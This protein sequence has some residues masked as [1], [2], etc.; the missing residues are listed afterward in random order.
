M[1]GYTVSAIVS[2]GE[3][4]LKQT[5]KDQP[6]LVLMD[7]VLQGETTGIDT[8]EKIRLRFDVPVVYLT[9]YSDEATLEKAKVTEPFG[10]LLKPFSDSELHSTIEMALYKHRTEKTLRES[11]KKYRNLFNNV[12]DAI[13]MM[14]KDNVS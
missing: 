1:L 12:K 9:A 14:E 5:E 4:A 10:Y 7:I 13:F 6:D 3:E 2:S 11:E 8:A